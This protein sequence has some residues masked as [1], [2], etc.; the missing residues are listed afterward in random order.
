MKDET[1]PRPPGPLKATANFRQSAPVG[2]YVLIEYPDGTR[3]RLDH[4]RVRKYN[5][6]DCQELI[7]KAKQ[8]GAAFSCMCVAGGQ[9]LDARRRKGLWILRALPY[10]SNAHACSIFSEG[11]H[12]HGTG[13][14]AGHP[15]HLRAPMPEWRQKLGEDA[16]RETHDPAGDGQ[17]R[18]KIIAVRTVLREIMRRA[19][20]YAWSPERNRSDEAI[21]SAIASAVKTLHVNGKPLTERLTVALEGRAKA[22]EEC[23]KRLAERTRPHKVPLRYG[24]V[25]L[26]SIKED[27][28]GAILQAHGLEAQFR[29]DALHFD[30]FKRS[31]KREYQ[32][33]NAKPADDARVLAIVGF[34][35]D[36]AGLWVDSLSPQMTSPEW[37]PAESR[38]EAHGIHQAVRERLTISRSFELD[39]ELGTVCDLTIHYQGFNVKFEVAGLNDAEYREAL[40]RKLK[41]YEARGIPFAVWNAYACAQP[42]ELTPLVVLGI[43]RLHLFKPAI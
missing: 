2:D 4:S 5:D 32:K 43:R 41:E 35:I 11:G 24:L 36:D 3:V 10:T 18:Q 21:R 13:G 34:Y 1:S 33:L 23:V 14:H 27:D 20:T 8:A 39:D 9:P 22:F 12:G 25:E 26:R 40:N 7:W 16:T 6:A 38:H 15:D 28:D 17:P 19:G 42:P 37:M 31:W 29:L 30:E